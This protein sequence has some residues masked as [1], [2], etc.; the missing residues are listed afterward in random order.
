LAPFAPSTLT[1]LPFAAA[2]ADSTGDGGRARISSNHEPVSLSVR[3]DEGEPVATPKE[4][5]DQR[6]KDRQREFE[7]QVDTGSLVVRQMTPEER[8]KYA[9]S[10]EAAAER[11]ARRSR[12]RRS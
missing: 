8:A 12:K 4:R 2:R 1:Y 3:P 10:P 9:E 11:E 6:K 5:E 7:R